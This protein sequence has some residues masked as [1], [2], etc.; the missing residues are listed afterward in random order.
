MDATPRPVT[1][2]A[3]RPGTGR[4]CCRPDGSGNGF[5]PIFT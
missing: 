5:V 1:D 4:R 2:D 3:I